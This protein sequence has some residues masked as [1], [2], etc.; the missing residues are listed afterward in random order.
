MIRLLLQSE[1]LD[2]NRGRANDDASALYL[3][4][5]EG[6]IWIVRMLVQ[7]NRTDINRKTTEVTIKLG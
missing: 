7:D 6:Y 2:V 3:A 5:F 4:A 1:D